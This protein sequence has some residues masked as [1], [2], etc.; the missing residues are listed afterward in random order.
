[1]EEHDP[2]S[3]GADDAKLLSD[4][5]E[6]GWHVVNVHDRDPLPGWAFSIGLYR[7]F[8]HPEIVVFGLDLE[9]NAS[10]INS[11]GDEIKAGKRFEIDGQYSDLID[12]YSCTFKPVNLVWYGA[13]LGYANWFYDGTEYPVLQCVWPDRSYRY[14]WEPDFNPHW[15]WAQPLLFREDAESAHTEAL[16]KSLEG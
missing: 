13:F 3:Q 7:N 12:E 9:L 8:G 2:R 1:M 15:A 5:E 11:V 4:V 6:Y 10:V 14:P 16:L